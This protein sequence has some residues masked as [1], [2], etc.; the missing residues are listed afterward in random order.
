MSCAMCIW[1]HRLAH[2]TWEFINNRILAYSSVLYIFAPLGLTIALSLFRRDI[3]SAIG[4]L[5]VLPW[6]L[7]SFFL[8]SSWH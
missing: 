8:I 5:S 3:F 1:D 7:L 2:V 4:F 6:L